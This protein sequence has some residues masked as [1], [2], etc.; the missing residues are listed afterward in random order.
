MIVQT[1][2][3]ELLVD[4]RITDAAT[5]YTVLTELAKKMGW[6]FSPPLT[7]EELEALKEEKDYCED[8]N[9]VEI[10]ARKGENATLLYGDNGYAEHGYYIEAEGDYYNPSY[11][12]LKGILDNIQQ[13]TLLAYDGGSTVSFDD[14]CDEQESED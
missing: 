6:E 12:I 3:S 14:W 9:S 7:V 8:D 4:T 13:A 10:F 11:H 2:C 1:S 5:A